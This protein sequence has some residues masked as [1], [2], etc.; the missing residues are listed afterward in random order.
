MIFNLTVKPKID[1]KNIRD[2]T[3]REGD[4]ILLDVKVIGEPVPDIDWYFNKKTLKE[5]SSLR[6]ENKPN[7]TR[8]MNER[9]FEKSKWNIQDCCC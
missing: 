1:R 8:F 6:V 4:P 5:T 9:S 7:N 3:V 2:M